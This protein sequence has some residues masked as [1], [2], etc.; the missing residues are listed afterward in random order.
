[1]KTT[2]KTIVAVGMT[3]AG[4]AALAPMADAQVNPGGPMIRT[5]AG[6]YARHREMRDDALDG[7]IARARESLDRARI[8]HRIGRRDF[9][10]LSGRL[11]VIAAE[12]RR[13]EYR[14]RG[15]DRDRMARLNAQLDDLRHDAMVRRFDNSQW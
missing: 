5:G 7:R 15:I 9:F 13:V 10:R 6:E 2:F 1:M 14:G 4:L 8:D 3:G 12:K 11:N